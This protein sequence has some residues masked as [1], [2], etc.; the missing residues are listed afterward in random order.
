MPLRLRLL[1]Y[2]NFAYFTCFDKIPL[3]ELYVKSVTING[4]RNLLNVYFYQARLC[5]FNDIENGN[6]INFHLGKNTKFDIRLLV[7]G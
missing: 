3:V 5:E 1:K 4:E 6:D 2:L 7:V